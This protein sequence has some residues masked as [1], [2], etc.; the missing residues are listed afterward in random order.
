MPYEGE[1]AHHTSLQRILQSD[2]VRTLL[3]M[4]RKRPAEPEATPL[5]AVDAPPATTE[6]PKL[7]VAIDGS[8]AEAPAQ[9]GYPGATVGYLTIASVVIKLAELDALDEDRPID[10]VAFRTT[11]ETASIEEA[12]PG[13]NI[14]FASGGSARESFRRAL[15][16]AL[17]HKQLDE[18]DPTSLLDTYHVLLALR[19][20]DTSDQACPYVERDC[21]NRLR[22]GPGVSTCPQCEGA[23]YSTD[24]LRIHE[25]F[26]DE[27]SNLEALG[28]VSQVWERVLLVDLLRALER[29][30]LLDVLDDMAFFVDGP[31]AVFGHPAWISQTIRAE[32]M[33]LAAVLRGSGR[34]ELLLLG[35]EKS[36]TFVN[37]FDTIDQSEEPGEQRYPLRSLQLLTDKY[38]KERVV[39]S[40]SHKVYGKDTYFGRKFFYKSA[41]G[42]RIVAT[43]PFQTAEQADLDRDDLSR[44]PRLGDACALL[45]L[46]ASARYPNAVSA[47]VAAHAE[48]AIPLHLGSKVLEQLTRALVRAS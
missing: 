29:R 33:R 39:F 19:S 14:V 38:I 5:P 9:T 3:G 41:R 35:I 47:I 22:I 16:E 25:G 21:T 44:Y 48:A 8:Y 26:R 20:A 34:R 32:L 10:P 15:Y 12:L 2:R 42:S 45:D 30:G 13:A 31:L 28:E 1:Y 46:L 36:G 23:I 27:G 40:Q 17:L 18:D 7:V 37:H 4:V 6:R 11:H 24:A 43:V